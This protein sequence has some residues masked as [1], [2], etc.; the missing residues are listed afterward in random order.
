LLSALEF[1]LERQRPRWHFIVKKHQ[2]ACGKSAM[3]K[4]SHTQPKIA[5]LASD[6][7][8]RGYPVLQVCVLC[9]GLVHGCDKALDD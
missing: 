6:Q 7:G 4:A 3:P 2:C 8:E 9:P 1:S 5:I